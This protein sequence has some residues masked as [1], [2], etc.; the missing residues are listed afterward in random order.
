MSVYNYLFNVYIPYT[1]TN[2]NELSSCFLYET[3]LFEGYT[4]S[5]FPNQILDYSIGVETNAIW[6]SSSGTNGFKWYNNST[7]SNMILNSTGLAINTN[8]I[9]PNFALD[10]TGAG[11]FTGTI[12]GRFNSNTISCNI[13]F[14]ILY[15]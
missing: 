6:F 1:I 15:K 3:T 2:V 13:I 14:F 5:A 7:S 9:N 10:V 8:N 11:N 12:I 4:P